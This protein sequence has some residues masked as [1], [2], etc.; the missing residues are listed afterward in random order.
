MASTI[1][2][3]MMMHSDLGQGLFNGKPFEE[4]MF[5]VVSFNGESPLFNLG[6]LAIDPGLRPITLS[7]NLSNPFVRSTAR[8]FNDAQFNMF[9]N[10]L[11]VLAQK[12]SGNNAQ[13]EKIHTSLSRREVQAENIRKVFDR[14]RVQL[15]IDQL[16]I[17]LPEDEQINYG[18][19]GSFGRRV[20]AAVSLML[21]NDETV[22]ASLGSGGL[23][24]WDDHSDALVDYP[25]RMQQLMGGLR[26]GMRHIEAVKSQG[27]PRFDDNDAYISNDSILH[28]DNIII[29]VFGDF[30]RIVN[31]NG[32]A[33]TGGGW[34]HGNN[35]NLYTLGGANIRGAD[36]L[37]KIVG[38]TKRIGREKTNG[39]F[40][41]PTEESYQ[42][43][44]FAIASS[45]YSYFGVQNPQQF[46]GE[47]AI[48]ES[49]GSAPDNLRVSS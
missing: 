43:E 45:V 14:D 36:A 38:S 18:D 4:L 39:Q 23:G 16:N 2:R 11:N 6:E 48:I 8:G 15:G 47:S 9:D 17:A 19:Y 26:A 31:L 21:N 22:F 24:G 35:Q 37:G 25:E 12:V 41:S 40:T 49:G 42:F 3:L 5:P 13:L 34:D 33:A 20:K 27:L 28:A 7:E 10:R 29:N 46:N 44:P 1:A 32:P 30:G